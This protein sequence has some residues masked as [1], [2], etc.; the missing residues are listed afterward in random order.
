MRVMWRWKDK[1]REIAFGEGY[2]EKAQLQS[3]LAEYLATIPL[4][5]I[6]DSTSGGCAMRWPGNTSSLAWWPESHCSAERPCS[7]G[8]LSPMADRRD[9]EVEMRD[10]ALAAE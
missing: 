8:G 4:G 10:C 2:R 3:F 6:S 7:A 9:L 1:D 5:D